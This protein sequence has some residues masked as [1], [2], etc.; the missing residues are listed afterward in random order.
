MPDP[1]EPDLDDASALDAISD[2]P[3]LDEADERPGLGGAQIS[4]WGVFGLMTALSI[5]FALERYHHG[6][7]AAH[8]LAAMGLTV[9][10]VLPALWVIGWL[11]RAFI[12]GE[13]LMPLAMV[14]IVITGGVLAVL[15]SV[16]R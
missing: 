15:F 9:L 5:Y 8:L 12:D 13:V 10:V 3:L 14:A 7:F 2:E 6:L 1:I 11:A 4:L 16:W